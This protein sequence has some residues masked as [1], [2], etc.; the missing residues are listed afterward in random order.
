MKRVL[1]LPFLLASTAFCQSYLELV[2]ADPNNWS[3]YSGSFGA[4]RHSA[5][6]QIN[7]DNVDSLMVKWIYHLP[8]A[9][10]L[11]GCSGRSTYQAV[12]VVTRDGKTMTGVLIYEP[13]NLMP[14]DF[15]KRF[16]PEEFHDLLALLSRQATR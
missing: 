4:Q 5:L 2:K 14:T 12:R 16:T 7:T 1:V 13:K 8:R 15:D 3:S 9:Q 6:K 10:E 11:E